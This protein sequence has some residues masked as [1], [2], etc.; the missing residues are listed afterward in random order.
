MWAFRWL[1]LVI[2]CQVSEVLAHAPEVPG[3]AQSNEI[4]TTLQHAVD[5][6]AGFATLQPLIQY[7]LDT[8]QTALLQPY[9]S[10]LPD[11]AESTSEQAILLL[12]QGRAALVA[13]DLCA[14]QSK[15]FELQALESNGQNI[16]PR[17]SLLTHIMAFQQS[18]AVTA[19]S[20][21]CMLEQSRSV[22]IA[23]GLKRSQSVFLDI[24]F[25]TESHKLSQSGMAQVQ[26]LLA[27]LKGMDLSTLQLNLIGHADTR[28]SDAYNLAL[29]ER[30]A[31]SIKSLL[32]SAGA[33]SE[34]QIVS[35]GAGEREPLIK[36]DSPEALA[37]NRRVELFFKILEPN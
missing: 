10:M 23:R 24:K 33:F 6:D 11:Y 17:L 1:V 12:L 18:R 4:L 30:R 8:R 36:G 31:N 9:L 19:T 16:A 35:R 25:A 27:A 37:L 21:T 3:Q 15:L 29:S 7:L 26:N 5:R 2:L 20:L 22:S 32:L 34:L 14:A 28:G 13:Q